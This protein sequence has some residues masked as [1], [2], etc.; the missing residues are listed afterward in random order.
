MAVVS[1]NYIQF[2][3]EGIKCSEYYKFRYEKYHAYRNTVNATISRESGPIKRKKKQIQNKQ[4]K[5]ESN[6]EKKKKKI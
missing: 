3:D 5:P 6:E 4:W 2:K 1:P